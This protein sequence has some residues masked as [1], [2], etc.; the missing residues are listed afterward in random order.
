MTKECI[1]SLPFSESDVIKIIRA[2]DVNKVHGHDNILVS[3]IKPCANF[4]AHPHILIIQN[5]WL[6]VHLVPNGKEQI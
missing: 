5:L 4:V 6:L 3:V 1:Y 2:L